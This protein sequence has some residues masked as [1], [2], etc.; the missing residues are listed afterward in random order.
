MNRF[1]LWKKLLT[2]FVLLAGVLYALPNLFGE[3]PAVQIA[4]NKATITVTPQLLDQAQ[5]AVRK[6]GLTVTAS[7]LDPNGV[8]LR[9][10]D[11]ETQLRAKDILQ[12][13][14]G[15]DYL[16]AL[17][18]VPNT[19]NW[20]RDLG[21]NPMVLGLDL[22]GGV[23][24]MLELDMRA[25]EDK[26]MEGFA[27]DARNVLREKKVRATVTRR[28][29]RLT[30][31]FRDEASL[32]ASLPGLKARLV[33][34][35]LQKQVADGEFR[36]E[37]SLAPNALTEIRKSA[38]EQNI[39]TLRKRV[40]AMGVAEPVVQ[41][42]GADRIVVQLPGVQDTTK[43]KDIIGRTATLEV[44]RVV[45]DPQALS[46]ALS[47]AV[48][49]GTVLMQERFKG[50]TRP[51]LL[52]TEVELTGENITNAQTSNDR[53][54]R[55]AVS[56]NLDGEGADIFKNL[57]RELALKA[58][59]SRIAMVLV[60]NGKSEVVTA[61][62]VHEEIGGGNVIITGSFTTPETVKT[63]LLLR[64]G[65]LAAPMKVV[66]ERT[67]GPSA[68]KENIER[69]FHSTWVGFALVAVL[70][71]VYYRVFGVIS[72]VS[73]AVNVF[74]LVS[75]LSLIHATLTLPGIA[76]IA[77]ALG[78]AIDSN[79]L[80]NERIR[81]EL[82]A[83]MS[84]QMAISEGYKHAWATIIDSNVTT[85]IVGLMLMIFGSG[86]VRG[87]AVVHCLGILTSMFSAVLVSRGLVNLVY[88]GRK[89]LKTLSI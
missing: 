41:Q 83:G 89:K 71:L 70:M 37:G 46:S 19:P 50:E 8:K 30:L 59:G 43:V 52:R 62:S 47:G 36:V 10:A 87:F 35:S 38:V 68:G 82:R 57:T 9:F 5:A 84:P 26:A 4:P 61:P 76:A 86:P 65:S 73:L 20:L 1:P 16:V 17:N 13:A 34:V 55:P 78:M 66:E 14:L 72:I 51:I 58:P 85:L 29:D 49:A 22:R 7:E 44:R 24:F 77:L 15:D 28:A 27:R 54:G 18:L 21:A 88:G 53:D 2:A 75:L 11:T 42:Q 74:L 12:K 39:A 60:E 6:A 67:V 80:I 40:N 32:D 33:S 3:A 69:G 23:H 56:I 25:A 45:E 31:K 63:A 64:S 48:P 81:E 79:V